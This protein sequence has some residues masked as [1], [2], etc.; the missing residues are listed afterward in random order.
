MLKLAVL[1]TTGVLAIAGGSTAAFAY[2]TAS[3]ETSAVHPVRVVL[4][5]PAHQSFVR[6]GHRVIPMSAGDDHHNRRHEPVDDDRRRTQA[7]PG[8]DRGTHVEPGDDRGG[9]GDH[10]RV[11]HDREGRQGHSSDD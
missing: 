8:D 2:A 6:S 7:E 4:A 3:S 9:H 5:A 1:A 11:D 10:D